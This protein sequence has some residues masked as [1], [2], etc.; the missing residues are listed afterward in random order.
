MKIEIEDVI[1]MLEDSG[2]EIN[3]DKSSINLDTSFESLGLDSLDMYGLLSEIDDNYNITISNDE[4]EK[5]LNIGHVID[6]I[7]SINAT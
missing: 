3:S 2:A 1:K 6:Y 4:A 7:S 5:L